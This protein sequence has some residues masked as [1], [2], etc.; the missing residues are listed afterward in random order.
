MAMSTPF[1]QAN[2]Q[3]PINVGEVL[4]SHYHEDEL[5]VAFLGGIRREDIVG[6]QKV[7]RRQNVEGPFIPNPYF[8][9]NPDLN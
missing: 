1:G 5:E 8:V 2:I 7:G 9:E 6:A 4:G 3:T